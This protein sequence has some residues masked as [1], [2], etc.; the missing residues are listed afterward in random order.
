MLKRENWA[1]MGKLLFNEQSLYSLKWEYII[2][3]HI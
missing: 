3:V 2:I 1:A